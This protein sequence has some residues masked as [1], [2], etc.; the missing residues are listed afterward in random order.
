MWAMLNEQAA[1]VFCKKG[2]EKIS[3]RGEKSGKRKAT[4][5]EIIFIRSERSVLIPLP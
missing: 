4:V 1:L 2:E 5:Y 3:G